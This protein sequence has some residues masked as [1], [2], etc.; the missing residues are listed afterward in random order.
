MMPGPKRVC[1]AFRS[2]PF[3][4]CIYSHC[5]IG[6]YSCESGRR[7][8]GRSKRLLNPH[9]PPRG[10]EAR[11]KRGKE[12]FVLCVC[13]SCR[14]RCGS[15]SR[16]IWTPT[17]AF[18]YFLPLMNTEY[19]SQLCGEVCIADGIF[20][21]KPPKPHLTERPSGS[22]FRTTPFLCPFFQRHLCLSVCAMCRVVC[23]GISS[24]AGLTLPHFFS[25][26]I[27][28]VYAGLC[29]DDNITDC[30]VRWNE[31]R[32]NHLKLCVHNHFRFRPILF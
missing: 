13:V 11:G 4:V 14:V 32:I 22:S 12:S 27:V 1:F 29:N 7:G 23:G 15:W 6:C 24:P 9:P 16:V 21:R 20:L 2:F 8:A 30:E 17:H 3:L 28:V 25:C 10:T 19:N 26:I 5:G 31:V 18:G